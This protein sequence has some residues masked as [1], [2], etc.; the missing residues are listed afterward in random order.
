MK[1]I[2]LFSFFFIE[3]IFAS[4]WSSSGEDGI[5]QAFEEYDNKVKELNEKTIQKYE[6]IS[7]TQVDRIVENDELKKRLLTNHK[8]LLKSES[9]EKQRIDMTNTKLKTL[10]DNEVT[11]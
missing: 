9:I 11:K 5:N 1:K 6:Q 7:K 3:F 10:I 8:E 4:A 2:F